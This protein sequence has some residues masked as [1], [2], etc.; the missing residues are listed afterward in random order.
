MSAPEIVRPPA[1]PTIKPPAPQPEIVTPAKL[2]AIYDN[3]LA[4]QRRLASC[5][6][7]A[8]SI[9]L[10]PDR[11]LE[12]CWCCLKCGGVVDE[13]AKLWYELGRAHAT[14]GFPR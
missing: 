10:A 8:F 6:G 1:V 11:E 2:R 12:K 13:I 7:H 4:N 3:A 14:M 5:D 9:D